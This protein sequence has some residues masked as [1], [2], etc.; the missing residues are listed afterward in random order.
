M[1]DFAPRGLA[2]MVDLHRAGGTP[3]LFKQLLRQGIMTGDQLT[4]TGKTLGENV[5]DLPE[6]KDFVCRVLKPTADMQI[7]YGTLAPEGAV[8]KTP[9]EMKVFRGPANVFNAEPEMVQAVAEGKVKP[10]DV[11]IIR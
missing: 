9:L 1:C 2:N 11:V 10:G 3:A 7:L 5:K 8:L 6:L 4:V